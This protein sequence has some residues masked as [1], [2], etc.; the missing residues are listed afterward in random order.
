M[1]YGVQDY[2]W[3][4]ARIHS[5]PLGLRISCVNGSVFRCSGVGGGR[6]VVQCV[7]WK[8]SSFLLML[9]RCLHN[10]AEHMVFCLRWRS[11]K[12]KCDIDLDTKNNEKSEVS[13]WKYKTLPL[14]N[15]R[16][17]LVYSGPSLFGDNLNLEFTAANRFCTT[18]LFD[19]SLEGSSE[20]RI[21][22]K[23]RHGIFEQE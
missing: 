4:R 22:F 7:N 23:T 8:S 15:T 3:A 10:D 17:S 6:F 21:P 11:N 16:L 1:W 2:P 18:R 13:F 12:R 14:G 20:Q 9:I 5:R 19:S